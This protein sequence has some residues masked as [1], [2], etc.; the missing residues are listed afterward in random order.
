MRV[1]PSAGSALIVQCAFC[2]L[3]LTVG[4]VLAQTPNEPSALDQPVVALQVEQEGQPVTDPAITSL[5]QTRVG[6]PLSMQ[7]VKET[8]TH[9]I[10]LNRFAD[11]QPLSEPVAGGVRVTWRLIPLHPIDR[12]E[13][14]GTTGLSE[15][16]LRQTLTERYRG[17]PTEGH[18]DEARDALLTELRRRGYRNARITPRVVP[19]HDPDRAT[20]TFEVEAG[21]RAPITILRIGQRDAEGKATIVDVPNIKQGQPYDEDEIQR[22]LTAWEN[23]MK[24]RNFY[25]ARASRGVQFDDSGAI[26]FV[27]LTRGPLV[28]IAFAGDPLPENERDKLVPVREQGSVDED[29]LEDAQRAIEG[30]LHQRGYRDASAPFTRDERDGELVITFTVRR[31][32][33]YLLRDMRFEGNASIPT[34]QLEELARLKD[35]ESYV[36]ATVDAGRQAIQNTYR[37]RGFRLAQVKVSDLVAVPENLA[38]PDR[39]IEVTFAISEGPRSVV[40]AVT[41]Q[42]ATAVPEAE[43]Q[44][45]TVVSPGRA[46]VVGEMVTD[47]DRIATEYRNRGYES[48]SVTSEPMFSQN[49]TQVDVSFTISEGPLIRVDH[50]II[51]GNRRTKTTTIE[52]ELT[53]R[54]GDPLGES[55]LA[56]S[57]ARLYSLGLFRRASIESVAHG[58]EPRRDLLVQ[59]DEAPARVLGLG[60]GLEGGFVSRSGPNGLAEDVFE[61]APRG[62][63]QIGRR[64]LFGKNRSINLYTRVSL[65]SRDQFTDTPSTPDPNAPV[66]TTYGFHEYRV[67]PSYEEPR[68]FGLRS[69]L[70]VQGIVEQATRTSFNFRRRE[71]RGQASR[72]AARIYLVSGF[73][74]LQ[75]VELFDIQDL[76]E[77]PAIDRL[78]PSVRLSKFSGSVSRDTRDDPLDPSLGTLGIVSG[79]L[80][81]RAIGSQVGFIKGY[82]QG[83]IYRR[84][85]VPRR[86]VLALG[87]RIGLAHGFETIQEGEG[88]SDLPASERFYAGGDTSV[89]GFT[90]DRLVNE[91]TITP[92]G[93]PTGGSG[94]I[95]LNSELRVNLFGRLQGAGF[96][97]AGNVFPRANEF[98]LT[99]LRPTAGFGLLFRS[100]VGPVRV[101]LGFNLH[102]KTFLS[103]KERRYTVH[104]LLGQAF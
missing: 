56:E 23:R 3:H 103:G 41:F 89:R 51:T 72:P 43:L 9:L 22:E 99:D 29:L 32:S 38:E 91:Q 39:G 98:T 100:P 20:L 85:P 2:I 6:Q 10:S 11:V 80:A 35:G 17:V 96:I 50:I 46:F 28:T 61:V 4:V 31:G 102:P 13:F 19:T 77:K 70:Q 58:G 84:L 5:I 34:A 36:R 76:D 78:F 67:V 47:R 86:V 68:I 65:R 95:I 104:V 49:D 33:R 87:A 62:F 63:F 48:V 97:D 94:V 83:F 1:L 71:I 53:L 16:D 73:Y 92:S 7:D 15:G 21:A 74:S 52:R 12:V 64:N 44:R 75:R 66:E 42:G 26:V 57:R 90:L 60:G 25:E 14:S 45:L 69:T 40:R 81:A 59:V 54:E 8:F 27:N 79:D 30:Y 18:V 101:D 24:R 37:A 88:V 82:F 55:A 93:F